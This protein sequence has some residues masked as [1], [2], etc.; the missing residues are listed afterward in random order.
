MKCQNC[1]ENE[2]NVKY[3]Q[4]INGVKKQM[5]ICDKCAKKLGISQMSFSMPMSFSNLLSDMNNVFEDTMPSLFEM[6]SLAFND[7]NRLFD[8]DNFLFNN[9]LNSFETK[10]NRVLENSDN[11]SSSPEWIGKLLNDKNG[12]DHKIKENK[13]SKLKNLEQR[14]EKEIREERYEDA[15]KTRDEIKKFN[16]AA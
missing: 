16:D 6:D 8:T 5:I 11:E 4:I 7:S 14:L 2:A 1:G 3:T 13:D 9:K 12:T 10:F 15:A